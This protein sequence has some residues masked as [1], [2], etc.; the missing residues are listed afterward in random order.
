M[1]FPSAL[2]CDSQES[3]TA[4][5]HTQR[6]SRHSNLGGPREEPGQQSQVLY[7]SKLESRP[8]GSIT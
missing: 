5:V 2:F 8:P 6:Q 4:G 7:T 1:G 3:E